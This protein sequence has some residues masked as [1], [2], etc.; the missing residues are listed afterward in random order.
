MGEREVVVVGTGEV[1][2]LYLN[3]I[4]VALRGLILCWQV[5]LG[6]R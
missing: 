6:C 4:H 2:P 1:V 3:K 5:L